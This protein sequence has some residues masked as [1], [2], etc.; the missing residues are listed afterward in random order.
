PAG[1]RRSTARPAVFQ[2]ITDHPP[3]ITDQQVGMTLKSTR[4]SSESDRSSD[5]VPTR[6]FFAPTPVAITCPCSP[7]ASASNFPCTN[8]ARSTD[9]CSLS[10]AEPDGLLLPVTCRHAFRLV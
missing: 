7:G 4:R 9:N 6:L 3:L 2:P 8:S 10:A 1:P 5:P